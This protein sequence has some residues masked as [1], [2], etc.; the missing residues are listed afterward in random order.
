MSRES[1]AEFTSGINTDE[2]L[3]TAL[4]ARFGDLSQDIPAAELIEFAGE[5]GYTFS[6]EEALD[7]LSEEALDGVAGG[8]GTSFHMV[9]PLR[10]SPATSSF[11]VIMK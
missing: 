11:K 8:A 7:R 4:G 10:Y 3:R 6:V 9:P 5:H 1:L 2:S